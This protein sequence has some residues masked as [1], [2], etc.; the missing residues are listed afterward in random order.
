MTEYYQDAIEGIWTDS[1]KSFSL[2]IT[3]NE[4]GTL[5]FIYTKSD[6]DAIGFGSWFYKKKQKLR[7]IFDMFTDEQS[8]SYHAILKQ[9]NDRDILLVRELIS[10]YSH[11]STHINNYI[12]RKDLKI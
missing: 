10:D 3:L 4:I 12:L 1:I 8:I 11:A 7:M 6:V 9:H 5:K 2:R